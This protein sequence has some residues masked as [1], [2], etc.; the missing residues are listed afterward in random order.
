MYSFSAVSE[1]GVL[2]QSFRVQSFRVQS[3]SAEFEC[4]GLVQSF[5]AEFSSVEFWGSEV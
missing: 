5:N 4:R 3:F 1:C 2:V